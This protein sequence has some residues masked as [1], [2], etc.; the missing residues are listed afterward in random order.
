MTLLA[1]L[2]GKGLPEK[3][4]RMVRHKG[5]P[6][7]KRCLG[8]HLAR[9]KSLCSV[10]VIIVKHGIMAQGNGLRKGNIMSKI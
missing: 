8:T 2:Q 5:L 10:R 7:D 9:E 1:R 6:P 4:G 3:K